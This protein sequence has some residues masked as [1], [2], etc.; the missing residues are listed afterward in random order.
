VDLAD[1]VIARAQLRAPQIRFLT[2]GAMMVPVDDGY[3]AVAC[4]ETFS[5][6]P[7]QAAFVNRMADLLNP[8]GTLILATQNRTV[9]SRSQVMPQRAGQILRWVTQRELKRLLEPRFLAIQL[10]TVL[11]GVSRGWL[12]I[13]NGRNASYV[14]NLWFGMSRWRAICERVGLGQTIRPIAKKK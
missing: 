8:V 1:E 5:H 7:D 4:V 12:R 9:F 14:W 13:L 3:D 6:I 11:P 10:A 2:G